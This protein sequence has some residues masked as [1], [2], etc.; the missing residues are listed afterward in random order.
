MYQSTPPSYVNVSA[1]DIPNK[2]H[3]QNELCSLGKM[4]LQIYKKMLPLI[5][6]NL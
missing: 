2:A 6:V 3:K 1:S 5:L 4:R